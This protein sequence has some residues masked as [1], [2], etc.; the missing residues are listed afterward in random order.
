MSLLAELIPI[1]G[2]R[3]YKDVVSDGTAAL[4]LG[5]VN[6]FSRDSG[7]RRTKQFGGNQQKSKAPSR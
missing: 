6:E 7:Q 1:D 4:T 2:M 5:W 3:F